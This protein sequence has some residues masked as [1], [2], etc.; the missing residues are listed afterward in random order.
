MLDNFI[1][2]DK[3]EFSEQFLIVIWYE[4]V[5]IEWYDEMLLNYDPIWVMVYH[6]DTWLIF[7]ENN[8]H[9]PNQLILWVSTFC[10]DHI[11]LGVQVIYIGPIKDV[12]VSSCISIT[13]PLYLSVWIKVFGNWY[14]VWLSISP[15]HILQLQSRFRLWSYYFSNLSNYYDLLDFFRFFSEK[16]KLLLKISTINW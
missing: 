4:I 1:V 14:S 10:T 3:R 8:Y 6:V 2:S 11:N 15:S 5:Y 16:V 12:L 9:T 7:T 13:I